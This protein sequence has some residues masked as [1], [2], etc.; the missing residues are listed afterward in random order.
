[1]TCCSLQCRPAIPAALGVAHCR[2]HRAGEPVGGPA[3][4]DIRAGN[5]FHD[6]AAAG[7]GRPLAGGADSFRAPRHAAAGVAADAIRRWQQT[8]ASPVNES[9]LQ[10]LCRAVRCHR[11]LSLFL[12][13]NCRLCLAIHERSAAVCLHPD[14]VW[15]DDIFFAA[16]AVLELLEWR[17]SCT[18]LRYPTC[19]VN[20]TAS[21]G[22]WS[23]RLPGCT[24]SQIGASGTE[25]GTQDN[26]ET[27]LSRPLLAQRKLYKDQIVDACSSSLGRIGQ[28]MF[29][30]ATCELMR[31]RHFEPASSIQIPARA[32]ALGLA[33]SIAVTAS[34]LQGHS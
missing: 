7:S 25:L 16:L 4:G 31:H 10:R 29:C 6:C 30:A 24:G 9:R 14:V 8:A 5:K 2:T 18:Y 15:G 21:L 11:C 19:C 13:T 20:R 34:A 26:T 1:M 12:K 28:C 23:H 17:L 3:T 33:S 32:D 22:I 27:V